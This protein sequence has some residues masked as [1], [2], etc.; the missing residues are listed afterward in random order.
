MAKL[1]PG[2]G[3]R[4]APEAA[5]TEVASR[6]EQ[7]QTLGRPYQV[8]GT[9]YHPQADPSYD[10]TGVASW[11]GGKFHGRRTANGEVFDADGL[12]A[13]HPTLPLPSYVRVTNLDNERSV[14]L[15]VNDRGPF[16]HSRLIDV[17][18]R[19]A[20]LLG[21]KRRGSAEVRVEYVEAAD[22]AGS[23]ERFLIASYRGPGG[24]P[25]T[26][27]A[28]TIAANR[29]EAQEA[30]E[31]AVPPVQVAALSSSAAQVQ[32]VAFVEQASS[33]E[34][35]VHEAIEPAMVSYRPDD[36][37]LMAFELIGESGN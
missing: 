36:R 19:A 33:A 4:Q 12:T 25:E 7:G 26:D 17:S 2:L 10:R 1:D 29:P 31:T 27:D 24:Y 11:Y 34:S 21:F 6:P 16:R 20:E 32:P 37:I 13:A 5:E 9:W 22:P 30:S 14:I 28:V 18:E 23:D 3:V 15:R 8:A 35:E